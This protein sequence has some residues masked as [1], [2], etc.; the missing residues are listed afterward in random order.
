MSEEYFKS[1]TNRAEFD[2]LVADAGSKPIFVD[3][4]AT[5]CGKCELLKPELEAIAD[6]HK[7][8]AVY[9]KVDVEENDEVA[10]EYQVEC[11]PTLILLKGKDKQGEMKG[12]KFENFKKFMEDHISA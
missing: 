7:D 1:A 4:Y 12:S 9:I 5:W 8:K 10:E 11:L 6:S 3:F 2:Q